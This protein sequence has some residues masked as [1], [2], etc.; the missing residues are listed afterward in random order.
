M[1]AAIYLRNS[2]PRQAERGTEE[3]QLV[4]G[5]ETARRLDAEVI[6]VYTDRG[7]SAKT[8]NLGARGDFARLCAE[9][10]LLRID[11]VVV[12]NVDRLTRTESFRELGAIWG[13]LQDAG[14]R[15]ALAGGGVLDLNS[16]DGMLLAMFESWR[17]GRE[18]AARRERTLQ[19]RARTAAAGRPP[20]RPPW[21]LQ[22]V[23][24]EGWHL[25]AAAAIVKEM[26]ER[27]ARGESTEAIA[28]DL[29]T[30]SV[31]PPGK[32]IR[33]KVVRWRRSTVYDLVVRE[34]YCGR[35]RA[36]RDVIVTVPP[37]VDDRLWVAAQEALLAAKRRGL[38]RTR[39][40][41]L[42]EG[43]GRC[44]LCEGRIGIHTSTDGAGS[45]AYRYYLC[46]NRRRARYG[47]RCALPLFR[48]EEIDARVWAA[49]SEFVS[50]PD[51]VAEAVARRDGAADEDAE[52]VTADLDGWQR[53]L[54]RLGD[55]ESDTL[56]LCRRGVLSRKAR[57]R[58]LLKIAQQRRLLE[59]QVEAAQ[60][61]KASVV[62]QKRSVAEIAGWM[63]KLRGRLADASPEVRREIVR[64]VV[65]GSGDY[66]FIVGADK[67]VGRAQIGGAV[68][69]AAL[70]MQIVA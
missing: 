36:N 38:R 62:V 29:H 32:P 4:V 3:G 23:A 59:Q 43:I 53:Q 8:G 64:A 14:V 16:P 11:L 68:T 33:S 1:R 61:M 22:Y 9:I 65:P 44:A 57:D 12:A 69:D 25:T 50:R 30:R 51:L 6:A 67:I 28:A 7:I 55:L 34:V 58:E 63:G 5:Q 66:F 10:K 24:G 15:I 17:A 39:G 60:K 42:M 13:P 31:S 18:N 37:I 47:E 54:E 2:D 56:A 41:Y 45:T 20:G 19:G 35:W 40:V 21:G 27:V 46:A 70:E 52:R 49:V 48:V 26:F